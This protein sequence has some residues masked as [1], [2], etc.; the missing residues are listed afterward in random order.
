MIIIIGIMII[1]VIIIVIVIVIVIIIVIM[2]LTNGRASGCLCSLACTTRSSSDLGIAIIH[3][4]LDD[5]HN[6][7]EDKYD[8]KVI[9]SQGKTFSIA[10]TSTARPAIPSMLCVEVVA[11]GFM[12]FRKLFK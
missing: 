5:H 10:G 6:F 1:I 3:H 7:Y 2:M 4:I 9:I 11:E 8:K 12:W